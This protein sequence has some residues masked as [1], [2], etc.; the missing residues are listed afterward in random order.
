MPK[1]KQS[2]GCIYSTKNH[3]KMQYKYHF[4][5]IRPLSIKYIPNSPYLSASPATHPPTPAAAGGWPDIPRSPGRPPG[6]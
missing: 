4:N 6:R 2:S 1:H 5:M 3:I